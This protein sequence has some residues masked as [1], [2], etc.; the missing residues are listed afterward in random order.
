MASTEPAAS[1]EAIAGTAGVETAPMA[2]LSPYAND[3]LPVD[4][5]DGANDD[6]NDNDD[7]DDDKEDDIMSAAFVAKLLIPTNEFMSDLQDEGKMVKGK[8][9]HKKIKKIASKIYRKFTSND[10]EG[11]PKNQTPGIKAILNV[12]TARRITMDLSEVLPELKQYAA[13]NAQQMYLIANEPDGGQQY[14]T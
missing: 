11:V 10:I 1:S 14:T 5:N 2:E 9:E 6:A 8:M 3:D 7:D 4:A 12:T 13:P